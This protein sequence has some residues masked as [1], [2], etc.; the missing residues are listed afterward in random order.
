MPSMLRTLY[1][2]QNPSVP[3]GFV[4]IPGFAQEADGKSIHLKEAVPTI[5]VPWET[6]TREVSNGGTTVF[7]AHFK[8]MTTIHMSYISRLLMFKGNVAV[9]DQGRMVKSSASV[10][11]SY[12]A[13]KE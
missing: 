3:V 4:A 12:V 8:T 6:A 1:V 10:Q 2:G 7:Q 5:G 11:V 13:N 9:N